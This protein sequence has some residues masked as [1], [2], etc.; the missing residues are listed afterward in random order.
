MA[1]VVPL[2]VAQE[3]DL[4]CYQLVLLTPKKP[5]WPTS[6]V[7]Q[8]APTVLL[9][10]FFFIGK[11]FRYPNVLLRLPPRWIRDIWGTFHLARQTHAGGRDRRRT[12]SSRFCFNL[13]RSRSARRS[14]QTR[15]DFTLRIKRFRRI[16]RT[17]AS[18]QRRT[19]VPNKAAKRTRQR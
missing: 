4:R 9:G 15:C 1:G 16:S 7:I 3:E 8:E 13:I 17:H 18:A 14:R 11:A 6:N 2:S 19:S 10:F 12:Q 5:D